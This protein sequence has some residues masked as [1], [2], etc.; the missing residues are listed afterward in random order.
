MAGVV[1]AGGVLVAVWTPLVKARMDALA[2]RTTRAAER[3]AQA[4]EAFHRLPTLKGNV[5]LVKDVTDRTLLGIHE[6]IPLPPDST[7]EHGL[8]IDLP[9]YVLRDIDADLRTT[10]EA[11]SKTGGFVLLIGPAAA[12]K[13]RC[14]YE[15]IQAVL[16]T[17]RLFMPPDASTLSELV[18]GGADLKHS[19][20]WLNETQNFLT[21]A[22]HLKAATVRRLLANT[23]HPVILIGTIWPTT[24]DQLR[25]VAT[26]ENEGGDGQDLNKNAGEVLD[27]ARR[28]SLGR[29]TDQEWGRAEELTSVDPR[30]G[31]VM[32]HRGQSG[33]AQMLSA[34]P[35]LIQRW[36][37]ADNPFG[38]AVVTAAVIA[39]RCGHPAIVPV[40]IIESLAKSFL[41]G[42]DRATAAENWLSEALAWACRPVH[43]SGGIAPIQAVGE[44]MGQVDGYEVS[45]ILVD[46]EAPSA[47]TSQ[48]QI[49]PGIWEELVRLATPA[50]CFPVGAVAYFAGRLTVA[51]SAW[52]RSA[53]AGRT[54]A[55]HNLGFL[56]EEQGDTED[57]RTWYTRAADAGETDA[58]NNLGLLLKRQG[59]IE[60]AR[61]WYT[62]AADAGHTDA[63]HNLGVLL[64]N[65]GDTED[66]RTWYTRAA[67]AGDTGSMH[68]LGVLLEDQGD[69]EDARTW[70]T[71]AADAG[72]TDAMNNLGLLLN[73]QGNTEDAR[74]WY[75]RAANAGNTGSMHNLGVL[76]QRRGDIEGART[77]YTRAADAGHTGS[78]HNLGL[79][80]ND[81]GDIEGARTWYTR[82]ADAGITDAMNNLGFLLE[83][84]G[85]TEDARTWYTRAAD[86]GHTG[87]MH[88]LGVLLQRRGDIEGARTW[89]TR[90]AS[91]GNT[92]SMHNLGVLLQRRGD[93]ED[94][95]TWYTR[96]ASAG[97]TGS[98]HNLGV[99]LADQG[100]TED[101]RTW[102]TRAADA[103]NTD[104]MNSLGILLAD[105]GDT[106]GARARW[107]RTAD[108]GNTDAMNNL[109][110]LLKR[111]GDIEGART[112]YTRAAD[113]GNTDAAAALSALTAEQ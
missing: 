21:G 95:R 46:Y 81:Q 28:F 23:A 72:H 108:A 86:A 17:W 13:T 93:T 65:Q 69:T 67:N 16:P 4:Q 40:P 31:Q 25:A 58:M 74:T 6:A 10:L 104:A 33:L 14:A 77:W 85:N 36:E 76:L 30:I 79:L 110:L 54:D 109:G 62:R 98:M 105:Q 70:Y 42:N 101:A 38:Q 61:T 45:D 68:N 27:L 50:A 49:T 43:N 100:D 87:S 48:E 5:T 20:V 106:E 66:A 102:Y 41:T 9:T 71:R 56:L 99:L 78:M 92:S 22:D 103:G 97:H 64:T 73:D 53:D 88:N 7:T 51:A 37:Q 8:S 83:E 91:A 84:Q 107:Q 75:T 35:E 89:Y 24:Y 63:M 19:V 26:T 59:D 111:Q 60:G 90:A 1:A 112:W 34:A 39:R 94:A 80:L 113:A 29:W 57:A 82:A 55:M 96:A 12:G 52:E 2:A 11:R 15:A 44:V 18:S 47:P 3:D 32:R